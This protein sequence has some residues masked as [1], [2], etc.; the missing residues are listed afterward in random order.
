MTL[1][2]STLWKI[3]WM[4]IYCMNTSNVIFAKLNQFVALDSN[5]AHAT[6]LTYV[7]NAL[8]ADY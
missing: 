6:M 2:I 1:I 3:R 7:S 5:A 8:T 4:M